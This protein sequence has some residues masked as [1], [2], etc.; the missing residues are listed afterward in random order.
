MQRSASV[1]AY[2]E[3]MHDSFV[4]YFMREIDGIAALVDA[5]EARLEDE[6]A[7]V[8]EYVR[9][10]HLPCVVLADKVRERLSAL[11]HEREVFN[12]FALPSEARVTTN[13]SPKLRNALADFVHRVS[14]WTR[15]DAQ[16]FL[17]RFHACMRHCAAVT[18][19][20]HQET[21]RDR[22]HK[23]VET[24]SFKGPDAALAIHKRARQLLLQQI[25]VRLQ[26]MKSNGEEPP[27]LDEHWFTYARLIPQLLMRYHSVMLHLQNREHYAQM[28]PQKRRTILEHGDMA[29]AADRV[30]K[31][32]NGPWM[33]YA[34]RSS[35]LLHV[36]QGRPDYGYEE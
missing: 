3:R 19:L 1:R 36:S 12:A 24:G 11:T 10:P 22:F 35:R 2:T 29:D 16:A 20:A 26:R 27:L 25:G 7:P 23:A 4:Q 17:Q 9:I 30:G 18:L 13:E 6:R 8:F 15:M 32:A 31:Y 33:A 14:R 28:Q 5:M 21:N 34:P